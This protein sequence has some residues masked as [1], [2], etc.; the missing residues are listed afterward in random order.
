MV[1][2]SNW[3]DD[4]KINGLI[5]CLLYNYSIKVNEEI[6]RY[7]CEKFNIS[8]GDEL[9]VGVLKLVKVYLVKK[10]KLKVGDKLVGCYGNKG[11]VFCIVCMEDMFFF[12]D[13]ILVDIVLN[14]LGVFLR[15]NFG[16]IF[17]IVLGWVGE[18]LGMKYGMLI[19]DGVSMEEIFGYI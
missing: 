13:G 12:D 16:Q 8:I 17:E 15:M 5:V 3:I 9:F 18:K 4:E 10:C 7:K 1:D 14:L 6:G 11:I 2:Y 19:F